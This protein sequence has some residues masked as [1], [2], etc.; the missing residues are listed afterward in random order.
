MTVADFAGYRNVRLRRCFKSVRLF[1]L[2]L[3]EVDYDAEGGN[4]SG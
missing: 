1:Y 3:D 2:L 4:R